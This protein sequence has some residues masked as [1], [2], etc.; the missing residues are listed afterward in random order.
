MERNMD[1]RFE[2]WIDVLGAVGGQ[3]EDSLEGISG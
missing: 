1:S 2:G 3:E